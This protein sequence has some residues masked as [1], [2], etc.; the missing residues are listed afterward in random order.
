LL[1][2]YDPSVL[3]DAEVVVNSALNDFLSAR[4]TER[5]IIVSAPAGAGKTGF[6]VQAV[7]SGR[8]RRYR[9]VVG[10]PTNEQAFSLVRRLAI[11]Y[12]REMTTFVPAQKVELPTD[13]RQL[14]NVQEL[15]ASDVTSEGIVVG[16]LSKLGDAFSR[17]DLTRFDALLI[18]ESYQADSSRY[19]AVGDLAPVH[20]LVGDC[21]QLNPFS[22]IGDP[23]H[24]RGL[25]E[26]PLQTAVGVLLRNHPQT[27]V[28]K[29]P[30]SRRLDPRAVTVAQAFY[31]DL[32][33]R[34]AVRDGVRQLRLLPAVSR[35]S[36]GRLL[37][38]VLNRAAAAGWA[39][40]DLPEAPVLTTDPEILET[41]C[42]LIDRLAQRNPQVRCES[43]TAWGSLEPEKIA[44]GVS[45]NDQKD[46]LRA[47]LDS[48]GHERIVVDTAN[49]LQGREFDLVI[50]WHP[51]AGLADP[52]EFHLDPGRLCV[53][54]T[55][56]RHACI[57]L[58]RAG[59]RRLLES[60]P[61]AT[62]AYLGWDPDPVYDGWS[63]HQALF[64]AMEQHRIAA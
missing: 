21:G 3:R 33:F 58:G 41:I 19:Y 44:V 22:A 53:L 4:G 11:A 36:R 50:A 1:D 40:L 37:D 39:H 8:R 26:D 17:G 24:W 45:H 56:H 32:S 62:P 18:D 64:A 34:A 38:Q 42:G 10:T 7:G 12:P 31:S 49:K 43:V 27:P 63:V 60:I 5:A 46:L 48:M 54:L 30:V 2:Y 47:R 52:D 51:L 61:P 55:R 9:L 20:M 16:T 14:S 59:D 28:Y 29:L 57:I 23:D 6:V 35:T 25:P 15:K 13:V